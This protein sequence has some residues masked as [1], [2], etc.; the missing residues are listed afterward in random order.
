MD[1]MKASFNDDCWPSILVWKVSNFKMCI[2]NYTTLGSPFIRGFPFH[3]WNEPQLWKAS[4]SEKGALNY[5]N[6]GFPFIR[7][8]PSHGW[9]ETH[10][11]TTIAG[12]VYEFEKYHFLKSAR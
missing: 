5:T 11:L 9:S 2:L 12:Q 1:E 10:P 8:F 3:G 6:L 4:L 7:G